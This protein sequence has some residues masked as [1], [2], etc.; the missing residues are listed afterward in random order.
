[1]DLH[2]IRKLWDKRILYKISIICSPFYQNVLWIG[3]EWRMIDTE[4]FCCASLLVGSYEVM[5]YNM[6]CILGNACSTEE[7]EI[8]ISLDCCMVKC[9]K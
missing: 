9:M 2:Q 7:V 1:M 8:G 6:K 5:E 3:E 4:C